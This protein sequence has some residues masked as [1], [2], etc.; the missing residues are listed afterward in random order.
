MSLYTI[1]GYLLY[2]LSIGTLF[3]TTLKV[4]IVTV[5]LAA[6]FAA[7]VVFAA[8]AAAADDVFAA[9]A[10]TAAAGIMLAMIIVKIVANFTI[11]LL[12]ISSPQN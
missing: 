10:F 2:R 11:Y 5:T 6:V 1:K 4:G 3:S 8:V 9:A 12:T 7:A